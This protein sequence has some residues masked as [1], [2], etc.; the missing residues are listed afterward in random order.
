MLR[1]K[2]VFPDFLPSFPQ[3]V[4]TAS[5]PYFN[6]G[7]CR[8]LPPMYE[9]TSAVVTQA[10]KKRVSPVWLLKCAL[11][12]WKQEVTGQFE[13]NHFVYLRAADDHNDWIRIRD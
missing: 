2:G 10:Q 6:M 8:T 1:S 12:I 4:P 7:V 5:A 9:E 13:T 11:I 3:I